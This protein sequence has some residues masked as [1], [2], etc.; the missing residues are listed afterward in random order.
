MVHN[1]IQWRAAAAGRVDRL[2][3][4]HGGACKLGRYRVETGDSSAWTGQRKTRKRACPHADL[5]TDRCAARCDRPRA[6]IGLAGDGGSGG[7]ARTGDATCRG[8]ARAVR[9]AALGG[10]CPNTFGG[11]RHA[12]CLYTEPRGHPVVVPGGACRA[13]AECGR[14]HLQRARGRHAPDQHRGWYPRGGWAAVCKCCPRRTG[15]EH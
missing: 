3:R 8:V 10:S 5:W 15:R 4:G 1:L 9:A 12:V 7:A 11:H 13:Q 6:G 14:P 2:P